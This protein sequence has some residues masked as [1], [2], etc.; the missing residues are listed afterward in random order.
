MR[1]VPP[2]KT[3]PSPLILPGNNWKR[4]TGERCPHGLEIYVVDGTHVRNHHDSDFVQGGNGFAYDFVP[5]N[6]LWLSSEMP[7]V[8]APFVLL[9]ECVEAEMMRGGMSYDKAHDRAKAME[10]RLRRELMLGRKPRK[11]RRIGA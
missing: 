4:H 8:E 5:K 6:E 7:D 10:D 9:H 1:T 2:W 3:Q 11:L